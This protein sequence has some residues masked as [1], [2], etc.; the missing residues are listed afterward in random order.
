MPLLPVSALGADAGSRV[1]YN[2][3]KGEMEPA[4]VA[5]GYDTVVIAQPSLLA[6]DRA[7]LGQAER[8]G[9]QWAIRLLRPVIDWVPRGVR[10]IRA[11]VVARAMP[12]A[13]A[14]AQPGITMLRSSEMQ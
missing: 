11:D 12:R 3:V 4:V 8:G 13:A 14:E 6:G 10:P 2:R 7:A 5:L 9:E 1:F